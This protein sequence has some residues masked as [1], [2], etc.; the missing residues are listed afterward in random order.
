M[1]LIMLPL[2]II[3]LM[4]LFENRLDRGSRVLVVMIIAVLIIQ[5]LPV[6]LSHG[7]PS[8][9][10][11]VSN[12]VFWTVSASRSLETALFTISILGFALFIACLS[13]IQQERLIRFV[14]L[15]FVINIVV[16]IIQLSFGERVIVANLLP[17]RIV[18]GMFVNENHF[19]SLL[20]MTVPLVAWR[21]VA[22][23][24]KYLVF[25]LVVGFLL[26][27]QFALGSRAGIPIAAAL[28]IVSVLW[29]GNTVVPLWVKLVVFVVILAVVGIGIFQYISTEIQSGASRSVY[30]A[31]TWQAIKQHWLTGTGLGSFVLIYPMYEARDSIVY[32]YAN[33]AHNDYLEVLLEVG[34]IA[35]PMFAL[36]VFMIIKN[37][38]RT[39][40]TQAAALSILA[41]LVHS[42]VDFPLR[43]MA[44]GVVFAVLS[45]I[46]LSQRSDAEAH[47]NK[48]SNL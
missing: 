41:V 45:A 3:G 36:Y 39:K 40:L 14:F 5:F 20:Y 22:T 6:G 9:P 2:V 1:H 11:S 37:I 33:H 44:I 15:G 32:V 7:L 35:V 17:Y 18:S 30:F 26:L 23:T 19:A 34:I 8:P 47:S 31:T 27:L 12:W 38:S 46:I 16:G 10:D 25:I 13:D 29:F 28:A 43:N 48:G 24:K 42:I 21:F 4:N